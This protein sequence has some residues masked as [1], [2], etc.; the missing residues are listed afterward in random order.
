MIPPLDVRPF[1]A[2]IIG[3][4]VNHNHNILEAK[5]VKKCNQIKKKTAKGGSNWLSRNDASF[6]Y[7]TFEHSNMKRK[8]L[9]KNIDLFWNEYISG[10][11][12]NYYR[13]DDISKLVSP[14]Y[15]C[16]E[17]KVFEPCYELCN[18][19]QATLDYIRKHHERYIKC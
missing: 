16:K 18:G 7:T 10:Q 14:F 3:F 1:F 13:S 12:K 11:I 6:N 8:F 15:D 19:T 5:L 17:N 2:S 9:E 4:A